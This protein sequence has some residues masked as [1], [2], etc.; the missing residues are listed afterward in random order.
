MRGTV[1]FRL[2]AEK[3][4]AKVKMSQSRPA[5]TVRRITE[6]LAGDGPYA[7]EA[8]AREMRDANP[9]V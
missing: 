5:D 6:E 7:S 4:V 1:G 8:L 2:R 3:L 9:G